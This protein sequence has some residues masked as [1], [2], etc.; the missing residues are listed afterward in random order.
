MVPK[1]F[2]IGKITDYIT[3]NTCPIIL[4][5]QE[6]DIGSSLDEKNKYVDA[7]FKASE[8]SLSPK[9][10]PEQVEWCR[11]ADFL[12]GSYEVFEGAIEPRDIKQGKLGDCYLLSA[13]CA[14]SEYPF[15]IKRIF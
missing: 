6:L 9:P 3:K 5:Y 2:T 1:T 7:Q 4:S 13:L 14:I 15:I 10:I 12:K 11:P 8:E